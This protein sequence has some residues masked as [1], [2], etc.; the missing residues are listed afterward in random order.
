MARP[1][2]AH[3]TSIV[4]VAALGGVA[5]A[6]RGGFVPPLRIDSGPA[7][8]SIEPEVGVQ[9]VIGIHW[10]SLYPKG[11]ASFD[12]GIGFISSFVPTGD[13]DAG[14]S[15]AAV[16]R[17]THGDEPMSLIGGYLEVAARTDGNSW[18]RTWLGMRV[19]SGS[20]S[21]NG[22]S[23]GYV[24]VAARVSTEVYTAG[25]GGGGGGAIMGVLAAGVYAEL[26]ARRIQTIG[27]DVTAS[28]GLSFR[29]PLIAVH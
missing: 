17:G 9:T 14:A 24:G 13:D 3:L 29:V 21:R 8:S 23:G 15:S 22:R 1:V 5:H 26:A 10:A 4:L 27:D 20:A 2:R 12:V 25:S 11:T 28:V 6:G 16:A 18:R 19:E 7:V